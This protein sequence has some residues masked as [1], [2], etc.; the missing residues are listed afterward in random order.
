MKKILI[1]RGKPFIVILELP[2]HDHYVKR[3]VNVGYDKKSINTR[4]GALTIDN[5]WI[6]L[7]EIYSSSR[8]LPDLKEYNS[9]ITFFQ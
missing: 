3:L 8:S 4:W 2:T 1:K 5:L 6:K 9:I 7:N